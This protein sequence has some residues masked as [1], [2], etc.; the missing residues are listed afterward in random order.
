MTCTHGSFRCIRWPFLGRTRWMQDIQPTLFPA[1]PTLMTSWGSMASTQSVT[2]LLL[3]ERVVVIMRLSPGTSCSWNPK[4]PKP[5]IPHM[6]L[7]KSA[8]VPSWADI[9]SYDGD[10][11][12]FTD[13]KRSLPGSCRKAG[14][15]HLRWVCPHERYQ[16]GLSRYPGG[17]TVENGEI[18]S[19]KHSSAATQLISYCCWRHATV[20]TCMLDQERKGLLQKVS[21][22]RMRGEAERRRSV[23]RGSGFQRGQ[24]D[25]SVLEISWGWWTETDLYG[26]KVK[27]IKRQGKEV[28]QKTTMRR[29]LKKQN[30][31]CPVL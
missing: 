13:V 20:Q 14:W 4:A 12:R 5:G 3:W 15:W 6:V 9:Q 31:N 23:C 25:T 28:F 8:P 29:V 7:P 27:E 19:M 2:T 30:N 10:C 16:W 24:G 26:G 22:R 1:P 18:N 11:C 21:Y 17:L